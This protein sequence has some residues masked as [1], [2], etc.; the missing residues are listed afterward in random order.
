MPTLWFKLQDSPASISLS[1]PDNEDDWIDVILNPYTGK[2]LG[3]APERQVLETILN[4]HYTLLAGKAGE[5]VMGMTG[6][7][8]LILMVTGIALWSGWRK[9]ATGFKIKWKGHLKR[10]NF[11]IHQVA[12][13]FS[14][15]F[16]SMAL[17]TGFIYNFPDF[18][19][20]LI[21]RLTFSPVP[22]AEFVSTPI[23]G[24]STITLTEALNAINREI[25]DGIFTQIDL[26]Q[27]ATD[28]YQVRKKVPGDWYGN[29]KYGR[30]FAQVDRYS[31]KVLSAV[32]IT[33]ASLGEKIANGMD[34]FH[35]G[36]FW[37][38]GG[39]IIYFLAGL[40]PTILL[41]TGFTMYRLRRRHPKLQTQGD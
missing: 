20:P 17:F 30:S 36:L 6:L 9:L 32:D 2:V 3:K 4:L 7:L 8:G 40:S 28:V 1:K 10:R 19:Y 26:P 24:K 27:T 21:Y 18:T 31:G 38:I 22:P 25:P 33:K 39:R 34:I 41:I 23:A 11:G 15:V 16:L 5:I 29:P 12:G 35:F 14:G 13:I 37:G